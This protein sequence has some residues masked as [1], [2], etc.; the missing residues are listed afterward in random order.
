MRAAAMM[1]RKERTHAPVIAASLEALVPPN[2]FYRHLDRTLDLSFEG[3]LV[4]ERY[5]ALG[6]PSVDPVVFFKML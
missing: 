6:R 1:G 4:A 5:A 2:H 3:D